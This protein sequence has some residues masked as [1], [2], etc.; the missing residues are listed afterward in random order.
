VVQERLVT[1][2]CNLKK[3]LDTKETNFFLSILLTGNLTSQTS[4]LP[5]DLEKGDLQY[6]AHYNSIFCHSAF[7][8]LLVK[9]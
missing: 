7:L 9:R 2:I 5:M 6:P 4:S 8:G 1:D 3:S